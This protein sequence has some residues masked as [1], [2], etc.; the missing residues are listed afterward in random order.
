MK[1][2]SLVLLAAL[3]APAAQAQVAGGT[4]T[5]NVTLA[6]DYRFRGVSQTYLGPAFQGGFDYAAPG[7][8]YFGNWNSNVSS[9]VYTGGAGLEM[10]FYGGWKHSYGEVT[11]DVGGIYYYFPQAECNQR[12]G[13]ATAGST[14]FDTLEAYVAATFKWITF[15][16]SYALTNYFG[17][18][19]ET[20]AGYW[21]HKETGA[22]LGG[23]GN[24]HGTWY[25]DVALTV[26]L[27]RELSFVGHYGEL[28]VENYSELEYRDWKLGFTY[29]LNGWLLGAA[30]ITTNAEKHFYYTFGSKGNKETAEPTVV[31]TVSKTF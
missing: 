18:G 31:F 29:D 2:C 27:T 3:A 9:N 25:V 6:S 26:P 8:I 23:R 11:L 10:D 16:Y 30:Y 19:N 14:K 17:L 13:C 5:G 1:K 21:T 22:P 24:S 4:I 28:E 12:N 7:G 20:A 15:K